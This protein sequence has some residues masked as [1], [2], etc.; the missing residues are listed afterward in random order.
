MTNP[1]ELQSLEEEN[2]PKFGSV[3]DGGCISLISYV[4]S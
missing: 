4:K 3:P 1:Q 2:S